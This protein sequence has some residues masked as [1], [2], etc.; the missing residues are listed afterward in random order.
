MR[1]AIIS[2]HPIQYN[3]PWFALLAKSANIQVKVF[4]T[5]GQLASEKKFDPGFG[6]EIAWDIPLLEG[7]DFTF[8]PN[9]SKQPG[10]HHFRGI[11]NPML[12]SEIEVFQPGAVLVFGWAFDSHLK[13]LRYFKG[14]LPVLFRGDSTLLDEEKG[15]K[16]LLR[17]FFL[18][19]VYRHIDYALY[20]GE[21]NKQYFIAHGIKQRQLVFAPHAVDNNRF[22]ADADR[23]IPNM[24]VS[25]KKLGIEEGDFVLLFAGKFEVKKN[26]F[27]IIEL[28]KKI[29]HPRAKFL[30]VG[31][32]AEKDNILR[33][34]S[35]DKRIIF[36]DFQ[37]QKEMPLI[38]T[39]A[40]VFILP[41]IGPGET[42]G[43]SVNEAMAC[44]KP[45][46]VSCKAG[47]AAD[48][49]MENKNG[50]I[51]D[52]ADTGETVNYINQL[53]LDTAKLRQMGNISFGH[54]QNF[55]FEKIV[56]AIENLFLK[57]NP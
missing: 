12:I 5:W 48:L 6:K 55:S 32:G 4:Y 1:L 43:L 2:S 22:T 29:T 53:M 11:I 33:A 50:L 24:R 42:W 49:V 19:W 15:F 30:M 34:A 17:R 56:Q 54:I 7:Y 16:K 31:N 21:N 36:S 46:L 52:T 44:K 14:R 38:Y 18:R 40:D 26:P 28:A 39:L 20:A 41:S 27:F 57:N 9:I 8:I 35:S 10:T 3:A 23:A 37:N 47:C 25:R 45:V 51:I 13:V